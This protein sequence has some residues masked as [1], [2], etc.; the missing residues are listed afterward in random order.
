MADKTLGSILF[1]EFG[2]ASVNLGI[3]AYFVCT[4]YVL[5]LPPVAWVV[6]LFIVANILGITVAILKLWQLTVACEQLNESLTLAKDH[7][8]GL[9]VSVSK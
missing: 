4:T 3:S 7:L 1:T 5:F 8:Q 2:V 6:L 9:Q